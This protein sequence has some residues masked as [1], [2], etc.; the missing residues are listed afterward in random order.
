MP[1]LLRIAHRGASAYAPENS[2]IAFHKAAA[3]GADSV[4]IDMHVTADDIPV[5]AHDSSLQRVFGVK[6]EIRDLTL[7]QLRAILPNDRDPIPTFEAVASTCLD[8]KLGLYLDVKRLTRGGGEQIFAIL[9][10]CGLLDY[11][12]FG[13]FQPDLLAEIKLAMPN[14]RTSILFGSPAIRPVALAEAVGADFVHPCWENAAPEPHKLLTPDWIGAVR[15]AKLGIVCWHE[16]RPQEIS[17]LRDLGVDAICS[18]TPEVLRA[19]T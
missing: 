11:T 19:N 17:A 13:S 4:E 3:M 18:D 15:A 9:M 10:R 5:A 8:L 7:D 6:A 1:V 14:V 2:L 16:E 12:I